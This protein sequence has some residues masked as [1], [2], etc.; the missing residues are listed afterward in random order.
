MCGIA[1][2]AGRNPPDALAL[3]RMCDALVHRGPDE[4]GYHLGDGVALGMRR[5]AI[6]DVA[7][8][9]Q[10]V[11]NEDRTV[12]IVYNGEVY[13]FGELRA[14][15]EGKGHR[16]ETGSDT[17][18]IVHLYEEHGERCVEHLRGMFAFA[19]W[20]ERQRRL[21]LARDRA[22]KKPLFYRATA[23]GI[24][25][26]SELKALLLEDRLPRA[27]DPLALHYYLTFGYVPAPQ[28]II[29]GVHKLPPAHTL[30]WCDGTMSERR[31]WRLAYEPKHD[32]AEADAVEAVRDIIREATRI[33]LVSERPLGAFLSGGI[34]SS[35]V[36]AAM[37]E[38]G[39]QPVKTF[40]IGFE[41]ARYDER[42]FARLVAQ[43]F[44]TDHEE[45]VV[46]PD[47]ADLLPRLTWHYDEPFAD[48]S[49]IPSFYLA[50]MARRHV[51]VALNGDGGD[52]SFGGYDRYVAQRLAARISVGEP[53]AK[54]G[55]RAV[56]A[57]PSGRHRSPMRR[58]KRF[59]AFSLTPPATRY[60]EVMSAFT[61]TDKEQL[62]SDEM[63]EAV[64][65][66]DA[67]DLV[68]SALDA[69]GANDPAEAAM[70]VDV[71]TY[72][73]GDLL[74][75]MDIATMANSLE[76]RSPLLDHKVMEFAAGLPAG[77]K[78]R[79]RTGKWLLKQAG[80][81][82]L[83]DAVLDRPKMGF[84]VPVEHWLRHDLRDV[85]HDALTDTTARSRPYFE[86]AMVDRLLDEHESGLDHGRKIW[87][88]LCFE[89][90]HRTFV[91]HRAVPPVWE[92]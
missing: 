47:I 42:S 32:L 80:R 51:V 3:R 10:P 53:L 87:T 48:S 25:F 8:G 9:R 1:G 71:Q 29:A 90:W 17:E 68:A 34:D 33:R 13:N 11:F 19:L 28:S 30:S 45:L 43:R 56:G 6:I 39:A 37:A 63:R 7:T 64:G 88:L 60:A 61:N 66:V 85:V 77:M 70:D 79:G 46:S 55:R 86:A 20:D 23:D 31:Y 50:E 78:I 21:L 15:L 14:E 74:V 67:Y 44:A 36:V 76:A 5:L 4:D 54:V 27:V 26:A 40:S 82:W 81:G 92:P 38:E 69:S 84:G 75:K 73:P 89:L 35:L 49:A 62:Y 18:C 59:L 65:D 83:P 22:G 24:W 16:F 72:L 41:D 91:D 2:Y 12:A 58:M 52:E 57:L